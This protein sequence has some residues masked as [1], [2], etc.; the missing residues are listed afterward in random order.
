M[1]RYER[2]LKTRYLQKYIVTV[3]SQMPALAMQHHLASLDSL[4]MRRH[5]MQSRGYNRVALVKDKIF[6]S[7]PVLLFLFDDSRTPPFFPFSIKTSRHK[8][9]R[10]E[11]EGMKLLKQQKINRFLSLMT[12]IFFVTRTHETIRLLYCITV[13]YTFFMFDKTR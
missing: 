6:V 1:L 2:G 9:Q 5:M 8:K 10:V 11:R 12:E 3:Q 7:F 13:N 4:S